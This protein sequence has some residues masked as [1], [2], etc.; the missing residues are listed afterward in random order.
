MMLPSQHDLVVRRRGAW[1]SPPTDA[2]VVACS[3]GLW[4]EA[5]SM[6]EFGEEAIEA[7]WERV[8]EAIRVEH[9]TRHAE[10]HRERAEAAAGKDASFYG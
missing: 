5:W 3:C 2:V 6:S 10:P 1:D 9:E 8:L 7:C 4:S